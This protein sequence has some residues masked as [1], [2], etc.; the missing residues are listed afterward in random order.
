[1]QAVPN[2][3]GP[4][5]L[6][7]LE[8]LNEIISYLDRDSIL[9][10]MRAYPHRVS[11]L[12]QCIRFP[13]P[14]RPWT[15]PLQFPNE[16]SLIQFH[17]SKHW[18]RLGLLPPAGWNLPPLPARLG[19]IAQNTA[20]FRNPISL[21][22]ENDMLQELQ[23]LEAAGLWDPLS[24]NAYG[25][26]WLYIAV[27]RRAD[28]VAEYI[29]SQAENANSANYWL[30]PAMFP[31]FRLAQGNLNKL[32]LLLE[33]NQWDFFRR[34]WNAISPANASIVLNQRSHVQ[35]CRFADNRVAETFRTLFF[36]N[37][38]TV[39]L[40][41]LPGTHWH[42]AVRDNLNPDYLDFLHRQSPNSINI[43]NN[44]T[45]PVFLAHRTNKLE[46]FKRLVQFG[47]EVDEVLG[48][49]LFQVVPLDNPWFRA[50]IPT[51]ATERR[52]HRP[53]AQRY[54]VF[55]GN[56]FFTIIDGAYR[57]ERLIDL[58]AALTPA[59]KTRQRRALFNRA[60]RLIILV[61]QGSV[62]GIPSLT[63]TLLQEFTPL[64]QAQH[65][66]SLGYQGYD[67]IFDVLEPN[68]V[69]AGRAVAPAAPPAPAVLAPAAGPASGVAPPVAGAAVLAL[70]AGPAPAPAPA[71]TP[72][73]GPAPPV[74]P[75]LPPVV[76][77]GQIANVPGGPAP[78]RHR[79]DT[80][81][82]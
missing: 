49:L 61:R 47:A 40:G 8:I 34:G 67:I 78:K 79:Y 4:L 54:P 56:D 33:K 20:H 58:N 6:R 38:A 46:H 32:D 51:R 2:S 30:D 45:T 27:N 60:R 12:I 75:G 59:Q 28:Q 57:Q 44:S 17:V 24:W 21:L 69:E 76:V 62:N 74:P 42:V 25:F 26:S 23:D 81:S 35:I 53:A 22:I 65:Y 64:E 55:T 77:Q 43:T 5:G 11:V 31:S 73:P 18:R 15:E 66:H 70:I 36:L 71:P 14:H 16:T 52:T 7:P 41:N 13:K 1:M 63:T 50:I 19:I 80:R 68:A 29:V 82:R 39:P 9:N 3:N 72:V 48:I 10:L 37:L